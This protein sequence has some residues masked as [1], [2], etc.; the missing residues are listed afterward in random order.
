VK[1]TKDDTELTEK[2]KN[3]IQIIFKM[4][5]SFMNRFDSTS[6]MLGYTRTEAIK[7]AMRRFQ[8]VNEQ[9]IQQRPENTQEMIKSMVASIFS[10]IVEMAKAEEATKPMK[11]LPSKE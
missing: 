7:E 8:E 2:S 9:K 3:G 6:E 5:E 1:H 4:P 11:A 10:P